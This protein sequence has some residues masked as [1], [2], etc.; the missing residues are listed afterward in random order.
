MKPDKAW[1]SHTGMTDALTLG[2]IVRY[3]RYAY[4]ENLL[5]KNESCLD[6]WLEVLGEAPYGRFDERGAYITS[7]YDQDLLN[8]IR[9]NSKLK[10]GIWQTDMPH[11]KGPELP[12][13]ILHLTDLH[14]RKNSR[15]KFLNM[16]SPLLDYRFDIV[17]VSGDV[18]HEGIEDLDEE[19][20]NL[21]RDIK[22][23]Y[24]ILGSAGNHD[25]PTWQNYLLLSKLLEEKAGFSDV[26]F[27][28]KQ[29]T[30]NGFEISVLGIPDR[31]LY[32]THPLSSEK[33]WR[34]ALFDN[35]PSKDTFNILVSHRPCDVLGAFRENG[36]D[37]RIPSDTFNSILSGHIHEYGVR[38]PLINFY[39]GKFW[40]GIHGV[41]TGL[42]NHYGGYIMPSKDTIF[43]AGPGSL[44][45]IY[46]RI[47]LIHKYIPMMNRYFVRKAG[48][49][50][51][52]LHK[53]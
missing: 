38:I 13:K 46:V 51:L 35:L 42:N 19:T 2:N 15:K 30:V 29:V 5:R 31:S 52:T 53:V 28:G 50:I 8:Y 43:S 44:D 33:T 10:N 18:V 41:V 6:D 17:I 45:M 24:K 4:H 23:D 11:P 37:F 1:L 21:L 39:F 48:P 36:E 27:N 7:D 14:I 32:S 40:L 49:E 9:K 25:G 20:L 34:K 22:A 3:F 26:N 47:P 12:I 16:H